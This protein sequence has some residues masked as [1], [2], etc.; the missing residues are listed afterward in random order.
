VHVQLRAKR[1]NSESPRRD[2][3]DCFV[4]FA[5]RN[6]ESAATLGV[7]AIAVEISFFMLG[8][9]FLNAIIY[10]VPQIIDLF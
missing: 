2:I 7:T 10:A 6:D 3:L 1:S 8:V 5:P 4:R 9:F